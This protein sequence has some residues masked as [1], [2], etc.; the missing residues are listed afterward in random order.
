MGRGV[1]AKETL[2][3]NE[4]TFT[5]ARVS[6]AGALSSASGWNWEGRMTR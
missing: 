1:G 6:V 4:E 3:Q 2:F 5:E